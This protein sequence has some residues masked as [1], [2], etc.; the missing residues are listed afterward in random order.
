MKHLHRRKILRDVAALV[1]APMLLRDRA[2]FS[3][4]DSKREPSEPD[5]Q[6]HTMTSIRPRIAAPK[7][8]VMRRG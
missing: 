8:S 1:A 5:Q 4:L 2:M 7:G 3:A 6:R